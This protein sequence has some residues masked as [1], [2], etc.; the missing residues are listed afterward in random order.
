[1]LPDTTAAWTCGSARYSGPLSRRSRRFVTTGDSASFFCLPK[2]RPAARGIRGRREVKV[3]VLPRH[4][5]CRRPVAA[6]PRTAQTW[7]EA[8]RGRGRRR[9]PVDAT[10]RGG[11]KDEAVR[12]CAAQRLAPPT[13]RR[14]Q[15]HAV[16]PRWSQG[17]A[18]SA[19][20]AATASFAMPPRPRPPAPAVVRHRV[21]AAPSRVFFLRSLRGVLCLPAVLC[22]AP[23]VQRAPCTPPH[24]PSSSSCPPSPPPPAFSSSSPPPCPALLSSSSTSSSSSSLWASAA[25]VV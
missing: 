21:C 5:R 4:R 7:W 24:W 22:N 11:R 10:Q 18:V 20:N 8:G 19:R 6:R 23:P 2:L 15:S 12:D 16:V 3:S 13:S 1:M 9:P 14:A 25:A 17:C